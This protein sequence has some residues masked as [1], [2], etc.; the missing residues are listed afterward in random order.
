MLYHA[1]PRTALLLTT[2][3]LAVAAPAHAQ[4]A[5]AEPDPAKSEAQDRASDDLHDR[6]ID[7]Q[8]EIIVTAAGLRQFDLL[9]G[10]DV[11]EGGELQRNMA[12]QVGEMLV[13]IPG[14]SASGF[15]PGASRP[16]LRGFSGERVKVL[17]DGIG[18]ID[19]SNT[20]ADHAVS[21]DPL[22]AERIEVL[23]GPA[24]LLYG[25]QAIGGAVNIIDKRIP[26]RIPDE[27]VHI[28]AMISADT[29]SDLR[30]AGASVDFPLGG[31]FVAHA[32][33]SWRETGDLA[34]PGYAVSPTL[35]AELL[36]QAD[37]ED[38]EGNGDEAAELREAA[39]LRGTVPNTAT[40]TWTAN[41][42]LAFFRGD[43]T[44]GF[45]VGVY[46]TSYGIPGR[47][48]AGGHHGEGEDA[49]AEEEGEVPVSIG[50]RQYRADFRAEVDLGE[51]FFERL[52][53][54][55]GY[56]D[57]THT[58]FEGDEVGTVFDVGGIEA[59]AE[60]VQQERGVWRG[61]TGVQYTARDFDAVGA[62]A[63]VAPNRTEQLAVFA[64]QEYGDG[65]VQLEGALR[66]EATDV[67]SRPLGL[68]R[69]F[70][71]VSG[72][73]GLA[74]D[75]PNAL[76]AGINLSRVGR[77]PSA[78]E[79]FSNGPHVATQAFEV[80]DPDLSIERAWGVELFARGQVG[81]LEFNVSAFKNWF[82]EY[83]YL[84]ETGLE[85]DDLPVFAYLQ[86]D[87]TYT[88]I[89]GEVRYAFLDTGDVRLTADLRGEYVRAKLEDGSNVP[90]IPPLGLMGALEAS[91]ARFDVRGE[92]EWF[93]DQ[94]RTAAFETATEGFTMVNASV[95]WHPLRGNDGVSL[96][97][98]ADNIFD[99]TGRRHASFTKDFVPLAGRN[100]TA[101]MRL[102]F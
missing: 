27:P 36:E 56:S 51:G 41:A 40:E 19:A 15:A 23:R 45:S 65:P 32:D 46:D 82:D 43:S 7:Y 29:A 72:A 97:L 48:G 91:T 38:A 10:T 69:S 1:Y 68:T 54:R 57:Y 14:V 96:V 55:A 6:R 81:D 28:D 80:G 89:E 101:S 92:V 3:V 16:I 33:G 78:E 98:K 58:E 95:T 74:Y 71:T 20:S 24:V 39:L 11:I 99:T 62:E 75:G 50:L 47:P 59:R 30:E 49:G 60:L 79:M 70:G 77:A 67:D 73:L 85:E 4:D 84:S 25:S 66:Y 22:T 94:N 100:F 37:E 76:R 86:Q 18:A 53:L 17:V 42:G 26:R 8:G 52:R 102:S 35:R 21:I 83:I 5:V 90:L 63:Y 2:A 61:A 12:G 87:A 9:A 64:L 88:G 34:I 44:M 93:A 13:S 31:G